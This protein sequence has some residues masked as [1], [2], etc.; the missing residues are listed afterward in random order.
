MSEDE[1][2]V[3]AMVHKAGLDEKDVFSVMKMVDPIRELGLELEQS[4]YKTRLEALANPKAYAAKRQ[5]AF[6]VGHIKQSYEDAFKG[7]IR[8]GMPTEAAKNAALQA[9]NNE[10][11]VRRQVIET[12]FPTGANFIGDMASIRGTRFC[13]ELLRISPGTS[14]TR[15]GTTS[16]SPAQK[17]SRA[18]I[19]TLEPLCSVRH[20]FCDLPK[21]TSARCHDEQQQQNAAQ[22]AQAAPPRL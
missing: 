15:P 4:Q 3:K 1:E 2:G 9:A 20:T 21:A 13:H 22:A 17:A 11:L 18:Q 8:A 5:T 16:R 6:D 10:K 7:F 19:P 12:Q 14:A